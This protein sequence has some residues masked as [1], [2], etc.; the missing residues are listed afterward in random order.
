MEAWVKEAVESGAKLLTGGQRISD[1]CFQPTVL[2]DPP[3]EAK[4]SQSEIFGPVI[5]LYPYTD[6][7][8]ALQQAN[9]LPYNFQAAVFTQ[10]IDTAMH[11]YARLKACA[12]M[13]NDH[14]AFRVDWM[15]FAGLGQSGLAVGGI[16]YT[17]RDMQ[18]EKL[19]VLRS[20]G[21]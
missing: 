4:V 1:S 12:V 16:P 17:M 21:L 14:T 8:Q 11:C 2:L 5:C 18:I 20:P 7:D 13:I 9:S 3:A 15:P 19:M 10:D 6:I